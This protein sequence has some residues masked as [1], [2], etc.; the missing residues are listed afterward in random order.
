MI[1]KELA[2]TLS[3]TA[4]SY[5]GE[6]VP[7]P[8]AR[9][10]SLMQTLASA[11]DIIKVS[12]SQKTDILSAAKIY[13]EVGQHYHLDWIRKKSTY[14][15]TNDKW[16]EEA[17]NGIIDQLYSCQAGITVRVLKDMKKEIISFSP[18]NKNNH[19]GIFNSWLE[20][21]GSQSKI[22]DQLFSE[23]RVSSKID[24]PMLMIAEQRLRTIFDD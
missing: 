20:T 4:K 13:F 19:V 15:P 2:G 16:S 9:E 1:T 3:T 22:I 21:H 6:G 24:I 11:C 14:I 7:E 5:A 17:L 18:A 8:I 23:M 10:I 12:M